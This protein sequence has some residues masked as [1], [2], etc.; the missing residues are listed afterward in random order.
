MPRPFARRFCRRR[1]APVPNQ[2]I[3]A[4]AHGVRVQFVHLGGTLDRGAGGARRRVADRGV[5]GATRPRAAP[6]RGRSRRSRR[7]AR[8]LACA[9]RAPCR[10]DATARA[11]TAGSS[12]SFIRRR[13]VACCVE[14]IA[15]GARLPTC[16]SVNSTSRPLSDGNFRLDGGAMFG[17]IP[18]T[19][20]SKRTQPDDRQPHPDEHAAAARPSRRTRR[21][22]RRRHWRQAR[23]EGRRHLRVRSVASSRPPLADAGL[24]ANDIDIVLATHLHFDHAGGFTARGWDGVVPRFPRA[25]YLIRRGEW[26]DAMHPHE[27]NRASYLAG[28]LRAARWMPGVWNSSR[29]TGKCCRGSACGARAGTPCTTRSSAS[30]QRA[31]RQSLRPISSRRSRMWICRGSWATTCTRWTRWRTS[32]GSWPRR[33]QGEYVIFFE[34]DPS[35][36]AGI[37]RDDAGRLSVDPISH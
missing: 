9:G 28:E 26:E 13:R 7:L 4:A 25:R 11:R 15:S 10:R 6:H 23:P 32:G 2:P 8:G 36:A 5:S 3:D 33:S 37:I 1:L 19:L 30:S 31:G 34:H 16:S 22:D 21:A 29:R 20:W 24:T 12:P 14:L 17:V 18:K 27:R 35:V